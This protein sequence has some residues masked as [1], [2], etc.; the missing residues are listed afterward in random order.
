MTRGPAI[1]ERSCT[2]AAVYV[3]AAEAHHA[4]RM[5]DMCTD[6]AVHWAERMEFWRARV[7]VAADV[8]EEGGRKLAAGR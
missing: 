5:L 7:A 6:M 3:A 4:M 1:S 2:R 8:V